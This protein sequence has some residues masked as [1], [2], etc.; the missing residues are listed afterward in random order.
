MQ[1]FRKFKN[2]ISNKIKKFALGGHLLS[3][4]KFLVFFEY[5]FSNECGG[6]YVRLACVCVP[7]ISQNS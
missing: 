6:V 4:N 2:S 5:L 7:S 3:K 1:W